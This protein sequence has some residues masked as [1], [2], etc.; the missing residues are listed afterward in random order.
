L[1]AL[2]A[3]VALQQPQ[4][5]LEVEDVDGSIGAALLGRD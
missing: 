2:E 5:L 3:G 4:S 1:H